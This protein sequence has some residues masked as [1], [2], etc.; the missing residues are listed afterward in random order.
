MMANQGTHILIV[1]DSP[2]DYEYIVWAVHRSGLHNSISH[3]PDA[4][5]ALD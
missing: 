4:D 3:C 1:E 5:N 2:E